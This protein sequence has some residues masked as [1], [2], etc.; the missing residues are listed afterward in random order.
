MVSAPV[1]QHAEAVDAEMA[2]RV[3]IQPAAAAGS[4]V[5]I[6][7][8]RVKG[9]CILRLARGAGKFGNL[10]AHGKNRVDIVHAGKKFAA[11]H[12]EPPVDAFFLL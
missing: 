1:G 10:R 3:D 8:Q 4:V 12:E 7:G 6:K 5:F 11:K 9:H 2:V